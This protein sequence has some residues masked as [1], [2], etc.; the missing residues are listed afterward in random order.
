MKKFLSLVL[1]LVMTM[2]LVTVS[3]G[4]KDFGDSADLSGEAYEEAVNVMSEMGIIDGYSDGDF[5]PQGTLTRQAAAK[6][7]A[8]MM[9]G[10]TTAESLGT[11]AA[12]FKDV[13]AGSSFAGYIA[14]CVERGLISGYA[15][16][17]F[18]PT[19]TLT[20][21][22][23][24]KMLLGAL[25][26][27]QSIEG[28]TGTNW[29]VNVA[30]RA[31]E[32]GLTAGNDEF[33]GSKA[34]TREEAAL[35][36]V[37]TLQATL[38]EYKDKGSSITI[39]GAEIV[40]GASEPTY[41]TSSIYNQATSINDDKDNASGDYTV[42]FA[43][44]YQTDLRLDG[45][46]DD[47]GR[48]A[49]IWSWK[50]REIGTYVDYSTMLAEYTT[51]VTGDELYNLLTRNTVIK[52]DVDVVIDGE[53]K[54]PT[55]AH[56]S[57]WF[58]KNAINRNN[59]AGVGGTGNGV[60]TQVFVDND[61]EVVTIAII[62]TYLAIANKDY[63]SRRDEVSFDVYGA[64]KTGTTYYKAISDTSLSMKVSGEDFAIEDIAEG[65]KLL[66]NI[67]DGEIQIMNASE[68]ISNTEIQSFETSDNQN[69]G[70]MVSMVEVDGTEYD[71]ADA[72]SYDLDVME[73]YTGDG[74]TNLKDMTYNVYLDAY[75]YV[76]GIEVVE[77]ANNYLFITGIDLNGSYR[78]ART[79]DATAIFMDG[80][81]DEIQVDYSDSDFGN[82]LT[83]GEEG[84]A[85]VNRWFTYT[86][87]KN[88]VYTVKLV[89]QTVAPTKNGTKIA[90]TLDSRSADFEINEK[91][92]Y[93][94]GGLAG[95]T[96]VYG[97]D[98]TVYVT[99]EL[100][101]LKANGT[102]YGIIDDVASVATGI[103]NV[104]LTV[105][106]KANAISNAEDP[107]ISG[108]IGNSEC[109]N[110]AYIL[111][112]WEGDII[113]AVVVGEDAGATKN[114]VYAHTGASYRERYNSET[115]EYTW[116]RYVVSD[117]QEISLTEI[118]DGLSKL[119][120]M[121][122]GNWYQ[123]KY[124]ADGNVIDVVEVTGTAPTGALT[125]GEDFEDNFLELST[126]IQ[127]GEDT[128]LYWSKNPYEIDSD[129]LKLIGRTLYLDT[130]STRGFRVAEDVNI[131]LEQQNN[132]TSKTYFET[133]VNA[134]EAI[135]NELNER[136]STA[137]TKHDY[138]VSAVIENGVATS[139]II[140]DD[141]HVCDPYADPDWGTTTGDLS[142]LS[143][144]FN[145]S[146]KTFSATV[147]SKVALPSGSWS[148]EVKQ[149]GYVVASKTNVPFGGRAA[150]VTFAV[151]SDVAAVIGAS[152]E[153][154]VT[155]TVTGGGNTYTGTRTVTI[156]G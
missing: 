126:T 35:Y 79:A 136:H 76:I 5:R 88:D 91:H 50:N 124:N 155:V 110:G 27:D 9:L 51:K 41:V 95:F 78:G 144:A 118:G 120:T 133:G 6:I 139:V 59:D 142:V 71:F 64:G 135:V 101:E 141:T 96:N 10:K 13:P 109:A 21:F 128:V 28:Y 90:Q 106:S 137:A 24:L 25:G 31:Y 81:M 34:C 20:G 47:F 113:A 93:L 114:L 19:G 99:V 30:G 100:S 77:K 156:G 147:G 148:M 36:A 132:N 17:T 55:G 38:V 66:V 46:T 52:Y 32:I 57:D 105:W 138:I 153:Y 127:T 97:T 150:G 33:V 44:R 22:A 134:L 40:T 116:N 84:S 3:A 152:G 108:T 72:A 49:R 1:A 12:P 123:V 98:E 43:E 16:G 4:A 92:I 122:E 18:R 149:D 11:Q 15:D 131:V 39:N 145:D 83:D 60:L 73:Y 111:Y 87:D 119:D 70:G 140:D 130:T 56:A 82:R 53:Y 37:N 63:D 62:N 143:L 74:H 2:S 112:N 69:L 103:S 117:G 48:P 26:Y 61:E 58:T 14:F 121:E 85:K 65:D 94:N 115:G 8:C 42:E 107:E 102:N 151:E 54:A 125:N 146:T 129:N 29:T 7:I 154:T 67:A 104:D 89:N 75:G 68:G 80:N 86:V 23:F 45:E